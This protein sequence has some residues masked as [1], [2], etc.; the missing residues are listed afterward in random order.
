LFSTQDR[1]KPVWSRH[2]GLS[3]QNGRLRVTSTPLAGVADKR[4]QDAESAVSIERAEGMDARSERPERG[5]LVTR[6]QLG[7]V[8][9]YRAIQA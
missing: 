6:S 7:R 8:E 9:A 4:R 2:G 3:Y 1:L 5:V